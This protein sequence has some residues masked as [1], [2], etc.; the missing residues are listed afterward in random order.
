MLERSPRNRIERMTSAEAFPCLMRQTL[1]PPLE[2]SMDRLLELTD[3]LLRRVPLWKMG[4][5]ISE[6]A[7][8]MSF[9]AMSG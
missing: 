1:R 6:D 4:C 8:Q 7:A 3:I 2:S 9:E 5:N